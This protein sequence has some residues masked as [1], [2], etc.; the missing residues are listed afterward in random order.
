MNSGYWNGE[1]IMILGTKQTGNMKKYKYKGK[2][3]E[4]EKHTIDYLNYALALN[5]S[6]ERYVEVKPKKKNGYN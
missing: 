2:I 3:F 5:L 4:C 1:K 6:R